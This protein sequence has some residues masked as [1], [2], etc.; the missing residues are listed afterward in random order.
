[1]IQSEVLVCGKGIAGLEVARKLAQGGKQVTLVEPRRGRDAKSWYVLRDKLPQE[2]RQ[3]VKSTQ[4]NN[5]SSTEFV[6][7]DG[8]SI[9]DRYGVDL[10]GQIEG[11]WM[12]EQKNLETYLEES[13]TSFGVN[14]ITDKA[15]E[16][17][18]KSNPVV[19]LKSGDSVE[20]DVV[21]DATG[22]QSHIL[23]SSPDPL[24]S[25]DP[26]VMW[27]YGGRMTG[28]F[29]PKCMM[30]PLSRTTGRLS[31]VTPW[32]DTEA[33]VLTADYCRLSEFPRRIPEFRNRHD[34]MVKIAQKNNLFTI[35]EKEQGMVG[36]IRLSPIQRPKY[37]DPIYAVGEAAGQA[38]PN[39]AEGVPPALVLSDLLANRLLV[40]KNYTPA[41]YYDEWRTGKPSR[42]PYNLSSVL[43]YERVTTEDAGGNKEL[44][45]CIM[46]L[47]AED[48]MRIMSERKIEIRDVVRSV[49]IRG[50]NPALVFRMT[51]LAVNYLNYKVGKYTSFLYG[52]Q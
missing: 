39:M 43:L 23:R 46:S 19:G 7:F 13:A 12:I 50:L 28:E 47:P 16:I 2:M 18:N 37:S 36:K 45:K 3:K 34:L 9:F 22:P 27:I 35:K 4:L 24:L 14:F 5:L 15:V 41:Q 20:S 32:S 25:D 49:L 51:K 21:I 31:W 8:E 40:N 10:S 30:F 44:Y 6:L 42:I 48:Q 52:T 17:H 38:C 33:D 29:N 26:F 11:S 1:M